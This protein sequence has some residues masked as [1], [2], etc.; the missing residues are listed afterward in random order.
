MR[1][2]ELSD[3]EVATN[4]QSEAFF[5]DPLWV[6]L[7]PDE[8][9][10]RW[11]L[12]RAFRSFFRI[13]LSTGQVYGVGDPIQGIA[14]WETPDSKAP[15]IQ[16]V[17]RSGVVWDGLRLITRP[18]ILA[19]PRAFKVFGE[20]ERMRKQY[21]PEPQ[22]YLSTISV[23]PLAQGQGLASK[24]IR[25]FLKQADARRLPCYTETMT[26]EN[27]GLYIYY[28]FEVMEEYSVPDTDL[29]QWGFYRPVPS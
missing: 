14:V 23:E 27:V 7:Y 8:N 28:G 3:L 5:N 12:Y 22:F 26:P 9:Q 19:F 6:Y 17:I 10:R 13:G 15:T 4:I 24:L 11:F 29:K 21:A 16:D 1:Q 20:F 18:G 25:P 2:L